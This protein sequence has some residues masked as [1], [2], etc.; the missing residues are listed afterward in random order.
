MLQIKIYD[1]PQ[2]ESIDLLPNTKISFTIDNPLFAINE[3]PTPHSFNIEIPATK[4]IKTF[5]CLL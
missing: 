2:Y 4:K 5:L 3:I 1:K